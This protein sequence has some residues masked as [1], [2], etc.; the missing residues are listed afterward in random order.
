MYQTLIKPCPKNQNL[1]TQL[2]IPYSV[3]FKPNACKLAS[4]DV[5]NNKGVNVTL[6]RR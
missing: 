2:K 3:E 1:K 5:I 4:N 6:F